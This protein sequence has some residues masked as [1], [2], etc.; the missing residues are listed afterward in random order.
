MSAHTASTRPR[1]DIASVPNLR[2]IG[3]T[4]SQ[5]VARCAPGCCFAPLNS[6]ACRERTRTRSLS[7]GFGRCST[8]APLRTLSRTGRHARGHRVGHLRHLEGFAE[9]GS[10]GADEGSRIRRLPS[11]C[12]AT[13][14]PSRCS[15][16]ATAR[17]SAF[18]ARSPRTTHSSSTSQARS[19]GPLSSAAQRQGPQ[20]LG[21]R[22]DTAPSR[23]IRR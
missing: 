9:R 7:F 12:S 22:G 20:R 18:R 16:R 4:Q 5:E 15:R 8:C 14:G 23:H 13:A 6:I 1:I 3:A 10:G 19:A 21:R 17:W 11:K 2:D